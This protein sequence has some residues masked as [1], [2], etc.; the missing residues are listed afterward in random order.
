MPHS[1][2]FRAGAQG[3]EKHL[4]TLSLQLSWNSKKESLTNQHNNLTMSNE[5]SVLV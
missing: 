4:K 3:E 1:D 2:S 5:G